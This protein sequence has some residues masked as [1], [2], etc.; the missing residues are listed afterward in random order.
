MQSKIIAKPMHAL[1]TEYVS[2]DL[3]NLTQVASAPADQR[4]TLPI[5][6]SCGKSGRLSCS[7]RQGPVC[8]LT[9]F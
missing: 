4:D 2:A 6:G 1:I 8:L 5:A 9:H 3:N 7:Q